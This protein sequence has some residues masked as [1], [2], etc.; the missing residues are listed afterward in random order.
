[1]GKWH[2]SRLEK[3][4]KYDEPSPSDQ[5]FDYWFASTHNAFGGPKNFE[6]FNWNGEAVGEVDGWYCDVLTD[7]A[8][9]WLTNKR[10]KS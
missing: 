3:S 10:D 8:T 1:M 9:D 7:E 5:G 2:L 6:K 4:E